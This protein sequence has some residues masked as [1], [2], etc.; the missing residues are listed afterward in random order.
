[1]RRAVEQPAEPVGERQALYAGF[2]DALGFA[3]ELAVIPVLFAL[4]GLWLDGRFGTRPILMIVFIVL[5]IIGLGTRAYYTY[6]AQM[7]QHE[8]GKPWNR[9]S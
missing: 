4:F 2:G 6:A 5:A 3:V 8:E 7:A 9:R 1:M